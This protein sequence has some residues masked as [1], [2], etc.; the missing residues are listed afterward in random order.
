MEQLVTIKLFGRPYTFKS[1]SEIA[2]AK[3]VTD[4]LV[5]EV[6]KV[7][8][9]HTNKTSDITKLAILIST[10]LNIT[11]EHIELKKNYLALLRDI[12]ERSANLM[13]VLD[14]NVR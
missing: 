7:E 2:K 13:R 10:A 12:S 5:T 8:S 4:F 3:E 11:N 1:E 6:A 9:Q 14:E